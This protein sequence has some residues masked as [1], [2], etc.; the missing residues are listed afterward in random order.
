MQTAYVSR[1][2]SADVFFKTLDRYSVNNQT[3][4]IL[5]GKAPMRRV[6]VNQRDFAAAAEDIFTPEIP[7]AQHR[8]EF[9]KL[10]ENL[11]SALV[12]AC[13]HFFNMFRNTETIRPQTGVFKR[14]AGNKFDL[15]VFK[16]LLQ[17]L[18]YMIFFRYEI[19]VS[20]ALRVPCVEFP[21]KI[22]AVVE[23]AE[24]S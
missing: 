15:T 6:P 4:N 18:R 3:G 22:T 12:Y 14:F 7:V 5:A 10:R 13:Q 11:A 17:V 1:D 24:T 2:Y 19:I 9:S 8:R 23:E 20:E 16:L 21:F